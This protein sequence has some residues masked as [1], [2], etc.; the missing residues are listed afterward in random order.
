MCIMKS[1]ITKNQKPTKWNTFQ[2]KSM[3]HEDRRYFST[4]MINFPANYRPHTFFPNVDCAT[5]VVFVVDHSWVG[6]ITPL[7]IGFLSQV[8]ASY[9]T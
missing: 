2:E 8:C 4:N 5:L 6:A 3:K 1:N 9:Q 7:G